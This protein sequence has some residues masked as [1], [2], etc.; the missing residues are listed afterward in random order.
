[1]VLQK[2]LCDPWFSVRENTDAFVGGDIFNTGPDVLVV[3]P[4]DQ[5]LIVVVVGFFFLMTGL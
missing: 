1:M 5:I 4:S 3:A 2:V